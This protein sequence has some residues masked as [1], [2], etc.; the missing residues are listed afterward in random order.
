M[1]IRILSEVKNFSTYSDGEVIYNLIVG[2]LIENRD[3][4]VS[5]DGIKSVPSAAI[6]S[7][8]IRL[9]EKFR[10]ELIKE[11]LHIVNSTRQINRLI[12]DRFAFATNRDSSEA[13]PVD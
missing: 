7:A 5:F 1:V 13:K 3:V 6:N 12:K 10:F 8:F 2:E 9:V 11:R 4:T